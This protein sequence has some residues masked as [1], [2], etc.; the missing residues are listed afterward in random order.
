MLAAA[1]SVTAPGQTVYVARFVFK[2]GAEIFPHGHPGTTGPVQDLTTPGTDVL[3]KPGDAIYYE[4][5]VIHTARGA[6]EAA[7]K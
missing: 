4:S 6:S 7:A 1:P 2:D 3:L 5:D